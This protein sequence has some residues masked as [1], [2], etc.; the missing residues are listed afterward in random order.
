MQDAEQYITGETLAATVMM[1]RQGQPRP[2]PII[3]VEG[4][5]DRRILRNCLQ[6]AVDIVPGAGKPPTLEALQYLH[7]DL[8]SPWLIIVVDADFDRLLNKSHPAVVILTDA[9][10]MDCEHVRSPA[11]EKVIEELCS[12]QKC[13]RHFK[14]DMHKD[15]Y[16]VADAVRRSLL[17]VGKVL[18]LLRLV[19]LKGDYRLSFKQL[20][21]TKIVLR[22]SFEIDLDVL[23]HSILAAGAAPG[24]TVELL[25]AKL[26]EALQEN[27]DGWQVCH[28]HDLIK[29]FAIGVR[30]FWGRGDVGADEAER[31][32]RL[33]YEGLF[34]WDSS[35]GHSLMARLEQ[36]G[37]SISQYKSV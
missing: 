35:M 27:Y 22:S 33:A 37:C 21:H 17:K 13:M 24:V 10:D 4:D 5:K 34:F 3:L 2:R 11:L 32:L 6:G 26:S 16:A 29:L 31:A 25:R 7:H 20:D 12:P 14:A 30:K 19:S 9:H 23:L 36:M 18:G 1:V 28:G 8:V 15:I